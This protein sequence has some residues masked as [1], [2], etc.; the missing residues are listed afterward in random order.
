MIAAGILDSQAQNTKEDEFSQFHSLSHLIGGLSSDPQPIKQAVSRP[1][2]MEFSVFQDVSAKTVTLYRKTWGEAMRFVKEASVYE[3]KSKCPLIKLGVF[4]ND[5]SKNGSLRS[6]KNL[7]EVYGIECDY[8]GEELALADAY[9]LLLKNRVEAFLYTTPSHTREKPRWRILAP[10]SKGYD[11]SERA[12]FVAVING[13]LGGILANESFIASQTYYYGRV[14]GVF[15]ESRRLHGVPVDCLDPEI[16]EKYSAKY[17]ENNPKTELHTDN[18]DRQCTLHAVTDETIGDL[19][20][21]LM[22]MKSERADDRT[23]WIN[24][25][26]ALAS[27]K[28]TP[29]CKSALDL[30]HEFSSRC[31]EK[32]SPLLCS[33]GGVLY[34]SR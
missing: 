23:L 15:Y 24:V 20:S 1:V 3:N 4:G 6:D 21:A 13:I 16:I 27:L 29:Y 14:K 7:L 11:P 10:L 28:E 9:S 2:V 31:K 26:E 12:K 33:I 17:F 19:R 30:A 5:R 22:E 32:Y 34:P 8:D 18:L 25:L